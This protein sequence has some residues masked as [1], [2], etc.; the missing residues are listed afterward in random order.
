[1]EKVKIKIVKRIIITALIIFMFLTIIGTVFV[2]KSKDLEA[3]NT[4]QI[5]GIDST[6]FKNPFK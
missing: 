2:I 6:F 5:V 1:L 3:I 4:I